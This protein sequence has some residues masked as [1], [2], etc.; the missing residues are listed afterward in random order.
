ML[1]SSH[2]RMFLNYS[3]GRWMLSDIRNK[4][5]SLG[6][7]PSSQTDVH[8]PNDVP[9]PWKMRIERSWV[10]LVVQGRAGLLLGCLCTGEDSSGLTSVAQLELW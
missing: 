7:L 5:K 2:P 4:I 8:C 9:K 1:L 6:L 10:Y 3:F